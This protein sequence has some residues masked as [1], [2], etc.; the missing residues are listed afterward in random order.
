MTTFVTYD[1]FNP[2]NLGGSEPQPQSIKKTNETI[3]YNE[4]KLHYN[5]GNLEEPVVSDLYLELPKVQATGI[6]L[7][8]D[9]AVGQNGPYKKQNYSMMVVFDLAD[10]VARIENQK[11]IECLDA[12]HS[13]CCHLLGSCKGKVKMHDFDPTR[14]G[15]MFKH[16]VYFPRDE[17]TGEKV[18]G[19]NPNIWVKLHTQ[20]HNRTLFTGLDGHP[21]E[22][23]LLKDVDITFVPLLHFE[24]VYIGSKASLQVYLA[25]AI[26]MNV[27]KVGTQSRQLSTLEKL[28][29]KYG[30]N[31]ADSVSAQLAELRME[32]Q[33]QLAGSRNVSTVHNEYGSNEYGGNDYGNMNPMYSEQGISA[34]TVTNQPPSGTTTNQTQ[35]QDYLNGGANN[36]V[37]PQ[38]TFQVP[39]NVSQAPVYTQQSVANNSTA[40]LRL[41][42]SGM[43]IN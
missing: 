9:D 33:D 37:Q 10:A 14:P 40:P 2:R 18:K 32:R 27:V 22:W 16:P 36:S 17:V 35:I 5:Y 38:Q 8:E 3:N 34:T 7:K 19:K 31:L 25:S 29:Q 1:Q 26:V 4:I 13:T 43:K 23:E 20:K 30:D 12:L 11:A 24:K 42:V 6:R 28:K 21:I 41:Q 15:G 39:N